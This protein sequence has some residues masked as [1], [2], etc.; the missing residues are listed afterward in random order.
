MI[1][2]FSR[3]RFLW[4]ISCLLRNPHCRFQVLNTIFRFPPYNDVRVFLTMREDVITLSSDNGSCSYPQNSFTAEDPFLVWHLPYSLLVKYVYLPFPLSFYG[5][6]VLVIFSRLYNN[7][8]AFTSYALLTPSYG[9][10]CVQDSRL[11]I[12]K[13]QLGRNYVCRISSFF[14]SFIPVSVLRFDLRGCMKGLRVEVISFSC[15]HSAVIL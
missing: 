10:P 1:Y 7:L 11:P 14:S 6:V 12:F 8:S 13:M 3:K 15:P 9:G 2:F 4:C 5:T